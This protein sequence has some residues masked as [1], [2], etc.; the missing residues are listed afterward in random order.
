MSDF[1]LQPV[2]AGSGIWGVVFTG[3]VVRGSG[4]NELSRGLC[5]CMH[6]KK[7]RNPLSEQNSMIQLFDL[8]TE[9]GSLRN[10]IH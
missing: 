7:S 6:G 1:Y 9:D 8:P 10:N 2:T 3:P 5:T 4:V